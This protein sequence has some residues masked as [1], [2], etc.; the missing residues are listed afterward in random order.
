MTLADYR[1]F[2]AEEIRAVANLRSND[3]VR[4]FASVPRE[5]YLGDPPWQVCS[6][7]QAALA[8]MGLG[9]EAYTSTDNPC[10]LYHNVLVA[11]DPVRYL[12]NGHPSTL[13]RW[14]AA[15]ELK[16]GW[17]VY[18]AGCG[19]GY[20]TAILAE[21]AGPAASVIAIDVDASL[22]ERARNN[23]SGYPRVSVHA[24]DGA[25]FDPGMCDAMLINAGVTHPHRPWLD[26]LTEGGCIV[27]PLTAKASEHYGNGVMVKITRE[28]RG[29]SA[30]VISVVAIFHFSSLRDPEIEPQLTKALATRQVFKL[31]SLRLDEHEVSDSCIV[32]GG[33]ICLSAAALG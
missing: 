30:Q 23:L 17:R 11:I 4:A 9:G 19:V 31:K 6:G 26:R 24:G 18:H 14:I 7:D 22:A 29:F 10:D 3:L 20:Y 32:H 25:D 33:E 12:N 8:V 16:A 1:Q 2:Y 5:K 27:L 28:Q 13:A 21:T 15:L